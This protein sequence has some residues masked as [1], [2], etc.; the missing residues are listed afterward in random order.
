MQTPQGIEK[1]LPGETRGW[2]PQP[3]LETAGVPV[4]ASAWRPRRELR[5]EPS[6]TPAC[7]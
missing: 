1:K 7:K 5:E 2:W 6:L 3:Q 4:D